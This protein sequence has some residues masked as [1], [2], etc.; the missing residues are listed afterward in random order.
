MPASNNLIGRAVYTA[1]TTFSSSSSILTDAA[2]WSEEIIFHVHENQ[3][4]NTISDSH[5]V[6]KN[7]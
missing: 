4:P 3:E 2:T 6:A 7:I 1:T 5:L